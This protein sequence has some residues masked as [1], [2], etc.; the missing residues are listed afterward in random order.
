[1]DHPVLGVG[2][3]N[4]HEFVVGEPRYL[5]FYQGVASLDWP[6][7]NLAE[8]LTETGVLGFVPYVLAQILVLRA[9]WQVRRLSVSGHLAWKYYVYL[10]LSYWITG[11]T[12]ASGYSP[13]NL[14]YMFATAVFLKYVLT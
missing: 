4:F 5:A 6:H 2:F 14:W 7:N 8:I 9:M 1:M 10:F 13:L 11:L 12:E 3:W